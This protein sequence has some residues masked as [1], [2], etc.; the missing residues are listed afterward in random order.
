MKTFIITE[1]PKLIRKWK[2]I[3]KDK[4]DAY[5]NWLTDKMELIE[6]EYDD[7]VWEYETME[8]LKH[9]QYKEEK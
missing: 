8:E 4:K 3:G 7:D 5:E 1:Y 9:K 6:E 2:A